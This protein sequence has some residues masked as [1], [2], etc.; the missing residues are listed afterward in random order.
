M[1]WGAVFPHGSIPLVFRF[2]LLLEVRY[3]GE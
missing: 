3:T 1:G 2:V